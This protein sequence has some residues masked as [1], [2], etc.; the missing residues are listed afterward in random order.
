MSSRITFRRYEDGD[1][2]AIVALMKAAFGKWHSLDYWRWMYQ[3]NPAGKP[4]VWVAQHGETIIGH[5]AIIPVRMRVANE[6][7]MGSQGVNAATHPSYQGQGVFSSIVARCIQDADNRNVSLTFGFSKKAVEPILKKYA[8]RVHA[9]FMVSLV[10]VLNWKPLLARYLQSDLPIRIVDSVL[11]KTVGFKSVDKRKKENLEITRIYRFDERIN[12][13]WNAISRNFQI[14]VIRN[15]RYLNWRYADNPEGNYV[16]YVANEKNSILGYCVLKEDQ[17][18]DMTLGLIVDILGFQ[19]KKT[20]I[21][22]LVQNAVEHFEKRNVDLVV[23]M[24]S[25]K[26]P[27]A[28]PFIKARFIRSP[29]RIMA[30][31]YTAYLSDRFISGKV[32]SG[33]T[34]ILLQNSF[35]EKKDNWFMM[36]GDSNWV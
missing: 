22:R 26:H 35:L 20:V 24:M 6:N 17:R 31:T 5:H 4:I 19:K 7:L 18:E 3:K 9:C 1:E 28:A 16:I 15:Q 29:S 13:F 25:E 2:R 21:N 32:E 14:V 23:C 36:L 8:N 33:Q 11:R 34:R 27:Y 10:K 12:R 30:L